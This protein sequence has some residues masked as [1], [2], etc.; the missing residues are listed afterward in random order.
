MFMKNQLFYHYLLN[1][2]LKAQEAFQNI[3]CNV[4][5]F[6]PNCQPDVGNVVFEINNQKHSFCEKTYSKKQMF[7]Y[8]QFIQ[9]SNI[10][11]E[12]SWSRF[13]SY[14][15]GLT[16]GESPHSNVFW[17][18]FTP[19]ETPEV[20]FLFVSHYN[21]QLNDVMLDVMQCGFQAYKKKEVLLNITL[22]LSYINTSSPLVKHIHSYS[23]FAQ[24]KRT[25]RLATDSVGKI[26]CQ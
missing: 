16:K 18:N 1:S 20:K 26:L 25:L 12:T 24:D 23:M 14:E 21:Y 13:K 15:S 3:C 17:K 2:C 10:F 4:N 5:N 6:S 22:G 8:L 11:M 19:I 7:G 9:N